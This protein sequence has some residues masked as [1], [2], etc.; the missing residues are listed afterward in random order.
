MAHGEVRGPAAQGA[1]IARDGFGFRESGA[2]TSGSVFLKEYALCRRCGLWA[3]P[4]FLLNFSMLASCVL[5]SPLLRSWGSV[6][7]GDTQTVRSS[8]LAP[9]DK[10]YRSRW[11]SLSLMLLHALPC[12]GGGYRRYGSY[13][14][15]SSRACREAT[16]RKLFRMYVELCCS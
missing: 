6:A 5:C 15:V 2:R 14:T 8:R 7:A 1:I 9:H 12:A 16:R 11:L 13:T 3:Q 10:R 4:F